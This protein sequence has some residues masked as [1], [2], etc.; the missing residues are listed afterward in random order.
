MEPNQRSIRDDLADGDDELLFLD[1]AETFDSCIVGVISI[2]GRENVVCY[3]RDKCIA[4]MGG[5]EEYFEFNTAGAYVGER[6]P[7]FLTRSD[8]HG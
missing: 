4:A 1:P 7:A 2:C 8:D 3:D 6:T 5:D